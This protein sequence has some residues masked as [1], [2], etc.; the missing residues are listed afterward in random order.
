M[1]PSFSFY[2]PAAVK[3]AYSGTLYFILNFI[4]FDHKIQGKFVDNPL[5]KCPFSGILQRPKTALFTTFPPAE[6]SLVQRR[7]FHGNKGEKNH[8]LWSCVGFP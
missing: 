1:S 6:N 2:R 7:I 4:T 5:Q 8:K 3:K